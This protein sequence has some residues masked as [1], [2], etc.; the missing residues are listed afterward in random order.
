LFEW[1]K[2]Y[3]LTCLVEWLFRYRNT[4][5]HCIVFL[6]S[7]KQPSV[8]VKNTI[9]S[10]IHETLPKHVDCMN[11]HMHTRN[12]TYVDTPVNTLPCG[13]WKISMIY[14][15]SYILRERRNSPKKIKKIALKFSPISYQ[16]L[17]AT[18][19]TAK[20]SGFHPKYW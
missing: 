7:H 19:A 16:Y 3:I 13:L 8:Y 18:Q 17:P 6:I 15:L 10:G 14:F 4:I 11:I 5:L 20:P 9:N 1:K 12:L 2:F